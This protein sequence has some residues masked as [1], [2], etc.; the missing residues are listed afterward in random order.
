MRTKKFETRLHL[1]SYFENYDFQKHLKN[2]HFCIKV[3]ASSMSLKDPNAAV[4]MPCRAMKFLE[5]CLSHSS[6]AA[7]LVGPNTCSGFRGK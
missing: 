1:N 7:A 4:F 6:W 2:I 3:F 5:N